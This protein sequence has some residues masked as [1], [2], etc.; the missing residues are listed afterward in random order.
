[1]SKE[2]NRGQWG[3]RSGFILAAIGSAIGL[4]N[5]WRFPYVAASNGGG[6]F[7]IPYLIALFTAGIPLL[8]LEFAMGHK[9]RSS[10]PGVFA[11]LNRKYEAL[12][13]FQT[14]ISFFIATYYVV[15]IGWSFSYLF[16]A[17][18]GAWGT[19]TKAFL[20]GDYLQLTD[21]PMNLGGLNLKVAAPVLLVWGI[22]YGV[23]RLGIKN[24]LEK[25]NK[26]FMPLLVVALLIIV[27]RGVTLP[28]AMA[29][30]DYFFTPDFSKLTDPKVWLAAYGQIFYSL[31]ICFSIIIAYASYLPRKSDIVNN[32]FMTG[33]GNCS[34]S[35]ISGIGVF[36]ILGFMAQTQ[37]VSV[38]EVSTAGV[39]LAF[40]VFPE[41]INQL[42]GMNGLIGG[43]FFS[44]LIFA[45]LSSSMSIMEAV[46]AAISDK[47]KLTRVQAL[48]RFT[49]ASGALS[50]LVATNGGLYVLDIVDYATNQYG[51]VIA[52]I[53]E[54]VI[55][56]WVFNL[57]SVR[58][59]VNE[60]SDFTVGKWWVWAIKGTSFILVVMLALKIKG[61]II[62][63]YGGYSLTALGVY[64]LGVMIIMTIGAFI[65]TKKKGS[66]EFE[67]K[68]YNEPINN[69]LELELELE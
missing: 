17:F 24:G 40:I 66:Q 46:V 31:S 45:G 34:F 13:W 49:L 44:T 30:L 25:A 28:G 51:I 50:L 19:D 43:I 68:I 37:G 39:G 60:L 36:S 33:L 55:L 57:E 20:F 67:D 54:L 1:M 10:V 63:P 29:G 16:F 11:K 65:L 22:N 9:I 38:A 48:N 58:V 23:L 6:A 14:L 35:L 2:E 26:I 62:S 5:I 53:L 52:G 47:F 4:G 61:E 7:L 12:G 8:I 41:A 21:S 42:P 64:G 69:E 32:A 59:Y 3:S 27:V 18:T 56:G 15:I